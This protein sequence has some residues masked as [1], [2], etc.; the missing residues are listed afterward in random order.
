MKKICGFLLVLIAVTGILSGCAAPSVL[1]WEE[2]KP[3]LAIEGE[4]IITVK[5][6]RRRMVE[7]AVYHEMKGTSEFTEKEVFLDMAERWTLSYF[8]DQFGIAADIQSIQNEYDDHMIE[9]EDTDVY[10]DEKKIL[11]ALRL[12]LDMNEEEFR[13]WNIHETWIDR[14]VENIVEDVADSFQNIIDSVQMEEHILGNL[15]ALIEMYDIE[16]FYPNVGVENL[17]FEK[18]L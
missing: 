11:E 10:G 1:E 9:I 6:L 12:R 16:C 14:N 4:T 18:M 2:D 7:Q 17:T 15:Q 3:L 13:N 5:D 8:A